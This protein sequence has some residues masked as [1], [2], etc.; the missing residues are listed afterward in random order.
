MA[1]ERLCVR[2][3]AGFCVPP[4]CIHVS[5]GRDAMMDRISSPACTGCVRVTPPPPG[6]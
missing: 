2:V 5:G 4:D 1:S 6:K 3:Y